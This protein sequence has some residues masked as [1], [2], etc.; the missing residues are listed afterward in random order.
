MVLQPRY[1]KSSFVLHSI[2]QEIATPAI[3][4][5]TLGSL[6]SSRSENAHFAGSAYSTREM[7][8]SRGEE[9]PQNC[10]VLVDRLIALGKPFSMMAGLSQPHPQHQ[11]GRRYAPASV[12]ADDALSRAESTAGAEERSLI[13]ALSPL[14]S[15]P[16]PTVNP[17]G[18]YSEAEEAGHEQ[19]E[20]DC[21]DP[22]EAPEPIE[23]PSE[24]EEGG[25]PHAVDQ[26]HPRR[27]AA[28]ALHDDGLEDSPAVAERAQLA[29]RA[30]DSRPIRDGY[31]ERSQLSGHGLDGQLGLDLETLGAQRN[32]PE[33]L[34][35]ERSVAREQI[36]GSLADQE[37]EGRADQQVSQAPNRRQGAGSELRLAGAYDHVGRFIEH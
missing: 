7:P 19:H 17:G 5:A 9:S 36:G 28:Q 18:R 10:E 34:R 23:H 27:V 12:R 37:A 11:R 2:P 26:D 15:S 25:N 32:G 3:S 14:C 8:T 33:K 13:D 6:P 30:G 20:P 22:G 21:L 35:G 4:T 16:W 29:D 24:V 1:K 31:L